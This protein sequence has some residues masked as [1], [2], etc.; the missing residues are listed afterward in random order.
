MSEIVVLFSVVPNKVQILAG[1]PHRQ[2]EEV[3]HD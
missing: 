3:A 2:P 1:I